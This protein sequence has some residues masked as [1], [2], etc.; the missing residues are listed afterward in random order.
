[1]SIFGHGYARVF[2]AANNAF[3]PQLSCVL[4]RF[5]KSDTWGRFLSGGRRAGFASA[6]EKPL[7]SVSANRDFRGLR[8]S[9]A[10]WDLK[11]VPFVELKVECSGD[12]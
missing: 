4:K 1:M 10:G 5:S 12:F 3:S 6:P 8:A 2:P 7:P 9:V 11:I